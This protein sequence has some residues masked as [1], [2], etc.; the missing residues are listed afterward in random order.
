MNHKNLMMQYMGETYS[1]ILC[2][3]FFGYI[4]DKLAT[5]CILSLLVQYCIH[6][7]LQAS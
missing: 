5:I 3:I 7:L 1:S 2:N 4:I 6:P